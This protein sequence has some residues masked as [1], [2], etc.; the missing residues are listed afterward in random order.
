MVE[1]GR[2]RSSKRRV[3]KGEVQLVRARVECGRV[4]YS[5]VEQAESVVE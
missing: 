3:W 2:V 5:R 4:K 1:R